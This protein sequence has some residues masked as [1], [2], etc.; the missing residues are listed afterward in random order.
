MKFYSEGR[1]VFRE[2]SAGP[3]KIATVNPAMLA[4]GILA[5]EIASALN[6]HLGEKP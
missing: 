5:Q 6:K 2:T 4:P 3:V 1:D